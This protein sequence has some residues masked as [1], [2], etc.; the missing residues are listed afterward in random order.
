MQYIT[1]LFN[2]PAD[3]LLIDGQYSLPLVLLSVLIAA[4]SSFMALQICSQL[5]D[6][7]S[8]MRR[9]VILLT[10]SI[11]LGGGVWAMHFI[12]MLA[13]ELCTDVEYDG[14]ITALSVLPSIAASRVALGLISRQQISFPQLLLG[15]VLVGAGIGTMHYAGMAAM[16]MAPLLRYDLSIFLVSIL[17]AVTLATLS[18]WIR[19]AL[20]ALTSRF[21]LLQTNLLAGLIMG[22]AIAGMHYT[23]MAAAR[24][25]RPPGLEL[26]AQ[27]AH[28]SWI[29]AI[30]VT[31]FTVAIISLVLVVN[32]MYRY[33]DISIQAN[34][35]AKRLESIMRNAIDGIFIVDQRGII[36]ETNPAATSMTGW[37]PDALTGRSFGVLLSE[38]QREEYKTHLNNFRRTGES[39]LTGTSEE[40]SIFR[41]DGSTFTARLGLGRFELD[42][43]AYFV[44]FLADI[45]ARVEMEKRM[46]DSEQKFRSLI[47]NI[48][49][50]AYRC[51]NE[52]Q[53]PMLF[54]SDAVEQITGFSA[55][56]FTL[57]SPQMSFADLYH[58]DDV[59]AIEAAVKQDNSFSLEYRIRDNQGDIHWMLEQGTKVRDEQGNVM[60]I[61]GFIMDITERK[62]MEQALKLAKEKA[63]DAAAARTAFLANMSHE[64]RT[65]MN[66]IIGFSDILLHTPLNDE[67]QRHLS[68]ISHS[69][70]S[71]LHLLNDIL[72]TAKLEKGKLE[73]EQRA[74]NLTE[75]MD[76]VIST[77]YLQARNKGLLLN[78][79]I[80]GNLAPYYLGAPERIRQVLTNLIGNAIKFTEQGSVA[81]RVIPCSD[82]VQ[83]DIED[84]G[85][86]MTQAQLSKI[87]EPFT[88]AD[89]S[90]SRRF[91]G[92][93]LGTTISKQLVELMGG[94]IDVRSE[95]NKGSCFSVWLPLSP[96]DAPQQGPHPATVTSLPPMQVLIVDD[97][98]QNL[99]LL[100]I[101][102]ER[103]GHQVE[104]ARDGEQALVRMQQ[105]PNLQLVLMDVQMPVKDGLT[106]ARERREFEQQHQLAALPIIAITASVLEEDKQAAFDAGMNGFANKPIDAQKLFQEIAR[107][108]GMD[109]SHCVLASPRPTNHT[110]EVNVAAGSALWGSEKR[111]TQQLCDYVQRLQSQI[112]DFLAQV[113]AQKFDA[114]KLIAHRE[115]GVSANLHLSKLPAL[116][117][118]L[119]HACEQA[120]SQLAREIFAQVEQS[121]DKVR[122]MH[123]LPDAPTDAPRQ[124]DRPRLLT[125]L[126]ALLA[127]AM[128]N[129]IDDDRLRLLGEFDLPEQPTVLN[130][131]E[132]AFD[133]FEFQV[134]LQHL[135]PLIQTLSEQ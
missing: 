125:L 67:Q 7:F 36:V 112:P 34:A 89:A 101:L 82:G 30:A 65:P 54:I 68:T 55:K 13:F 37:Q 38:Q 84:T 76:M 107:V 83:F 16:Q 46:R 28:I 106:A 40:I 6:S 58:P 129:Q 43:E 102:L 22:C 115:K 3:S 4:F 51:L 88:Q 1:S 98:E 105:L 59:A 62:N 85:I 118:D 121:I 122:H 73:L 116:F 45:S 25:V 32:L 56:T 117:A 134:A 39:V 80:S 132:Q 81:I 60:W 93:G 104:C 130:A 95:L 27:T 49:G 109:V 111:Y 71:L 33:R 91:G 23:G 113:G 64:I 90:M 48:P 9:R 92:T 135:K 75:E 69:S 57:P 26:S 47:T 2:I 133:D 110:E 74:F 8:A 97:I 96:T 20:S 86:G 119:E 15:G 18:L 44:A 114:L 128:E 99:E 19:F 42:N 131:I 126:Q 72:D 94:R 14:L 108:M 123:C 87:F 103:Q 53:W 127:D 124:Q 100:Q 79:E 24:F 50:I 120:D 63:E 52:P 70:R 31:V 41:P 10:G 35:N 66:A 21:N 29:L 17:V 77:L 78:T 5:R 12:G 11:A 61:D